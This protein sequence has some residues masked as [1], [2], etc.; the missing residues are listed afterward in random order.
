MKPLIIALLCLI[1]LLSAD[2]H[3]SGNPCYDF[4][5]SI[6]ARNNRAPN[7]VEMNLSALSVAGYYH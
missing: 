5:D 1:A 3:E 4:A 6:I 7:A 2:Q